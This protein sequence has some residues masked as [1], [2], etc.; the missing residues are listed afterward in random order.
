MEDSNEDRLFWFEKPDSSE[1]KLFAIFIKENNNIL[2]KF[3]DH[4][5]MYSESEMLRLI[6]LLN[7]Y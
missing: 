1:R 3:Q 6:N 2:Y 7:F 4:G 5:G